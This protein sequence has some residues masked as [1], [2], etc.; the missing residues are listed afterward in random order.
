[1]RAGAPGGQVQLHAVTGSHQEE[2]AVKSNS[3]WTVM[4]LTVFV[5][6]E[7]ALECVCG[8]GRGAGGF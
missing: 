6:R 3:L 5:G 1:M 2:A 7:G 4:E 8:G